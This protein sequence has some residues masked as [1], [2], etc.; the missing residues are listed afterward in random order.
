MFTRGRKTEIV[1]I[2]FKRWGDEDRAVYAGLVHQ[3][4]HFVLGVGDRPVGALRPQ[5]PGPLGRILRPNMNLRVDDDD[6]ER[7]ILTRKT[8]KAGQQSR[9]AFSACSCGL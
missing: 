3:M 8:K 6:G 5:N 7:S 1:A 9:P 2:A 4:Q